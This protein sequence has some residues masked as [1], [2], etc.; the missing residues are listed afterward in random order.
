MGTH[1]LAGEYNNLT[2]F[3]IDTILRLENTVDPSHPL[4]LSVVNIVG[5]GDEAWSVQEL[6]VQGICKNGK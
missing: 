5:G 1:P 3:E 2:I 4:E 6:H